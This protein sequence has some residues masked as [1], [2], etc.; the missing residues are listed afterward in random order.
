MSCSFDISDLSRVRD[1]G[2]CLRGGPEAQ[3]PAAE[4][5]RAHREPA[6]T[7]RQTGD[8]VGQPMDVEQYAARG[9]RHGDPRR[10]TREHRSNRATAPPTE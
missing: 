7:E 8:H 6:P 5:D 2:N 3:D 1:S 10:E 9:H 4:R